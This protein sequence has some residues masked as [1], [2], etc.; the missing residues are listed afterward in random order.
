V[1]SILIIT[2]QYI[3]EAVGRASRMHELAKALKKFYKI[4][5]IAPPPTWPYS[6]FP[7]VSYLTY[8]EVIDEVD[9]L[10]IWTHQPTKE[11]PSA[12]SK[13]AYHLIFPINVCFSFISTL[14]NVSTVIISAQPPPIL[15]SALLVI[16]ARKKLILDIGDL[17]YGEEIDRKRIKL[18]IFKKIIKKIQLYC[19]KKSDFIITNTLGIQTRIQKILEEDKPDKVKYFPFNV[20]LKLFKKQENTIT[21][22]KIIYTGMFGALQN[23]KPLIKAMKV[24]VKKYPDMKLHLYGGG[25]YQSDVQNLIMQLDLQD[26]CEIHHPVPRNELPLILSTAMIGV[27]S[28]S[29]DESLSFA[30]PSKT[31][32]YMACGLP[33]FGYGASD[34]IK[35]ILEKNRCGLYL[36]TDDP[37]ELSKGILEMIQNQRNLDEYSKNGVKFVESRVNINELTKLIETISNHSAD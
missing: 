24:V 20:D 28:L 37:V 9:V 15:F 16:F 36:K 1:K 25:K 21:E 19:W 35:E 32:E 2:T 29:M 23:L 26:N 18:S 11:S 30:N 13:L 5:V 8:K 10:R 14:R 12:V 31:F 34:A 27:V 6:K 17:D 33:V 4:R 7:K 3:P 22:K